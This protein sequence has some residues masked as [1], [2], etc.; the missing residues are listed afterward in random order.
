[1]SAAVALA[2][3]RGVPRSFARALVRAPSGRPL[4]PARAAAQHA[5]YVAALIALDVA[6][7]ELP[8]DEAFPDGCF[9][10]DTAVI[11]GDLAVMT[12]PGAPSRRG[13]GAAVRAALGQHTDLGIVD[14][15]DSVRLDGG[16]V[17]VLGETLIVGASE[18]SDAAGALA[19]AEAV[20]ARGG[21]VVRAPVPGA[22]HLKCHASVAAPGVVV[23]A[24][25]WLAPELL[26][27]GWELLEVPAEEAFAANVVAI[28]GPARA[29]LVHSGYPET[30]RRLEA[31]GIGAMLVDTSELARADGSL[32]CCS[33][34]VPVGS[35]CAW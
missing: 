11:V 23:A 21:R 30:A 26:P 5:E 13:E 4:D 6:V 17:L 32:T 25:G 7:V 3:V 28:P 1:M 31:A 33:I 35:S 9:V 34:V 10:E 15:P 24:E 2:I 27:V 8:A 20:S 29:A 19:L 22:L 14:L 12:R 18:R 16:D